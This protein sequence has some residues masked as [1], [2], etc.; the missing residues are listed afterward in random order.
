MRKQIQLAGSIISR[1]LEGMKAVLEIP[2]KL[3]RE[4]E[5]VAA[6]NGQALGV[7]V[8]DAIQAKLG[9]DTCQASKPWAKHFGSLRHL[10]EE[11]ARIEQIVA[12][13]FRT[14]DSEN[15]R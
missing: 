6:R 15:W 8:A 14:V 9:S 3:L 5:K 10:H 7:F 13:E 11:S 1:L 4:A 2:E 12:D